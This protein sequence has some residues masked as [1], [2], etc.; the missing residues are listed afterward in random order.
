MFDRIHAAFVSLLVALG[1]AQPATVTYQGYGEGEYVLVAPQIAGTLEALDVER[2]QTVHKG[3]PL[4][5]LDSTD[6]TAALEQAKAQVLAARASLDDMIKAKR[7]SE[8]DTLV[9]Q[10]DQADA[11]L[12][13]AVVTYARDQQQ[14]KIKAVSQQTL[15]ADKAAVDQ[16][17][18]H[19]AETEA[20]VATGQLSTGRDDAIHAA[21]A[22]VAVD[23]AAVAEAQWRLDQ[24][25]LVAPTDAFVFDTLYRPGEYIAAGQPVVSL[26]PAP[27]IRA[28]FFVPEPKLA[29]VPAGTEV[30]IHCDSCTE[31]IPAHVTYVSPQAE[32]SPPELYNQD[33]RARLL[34]MLEATPDENPELLHPGQPVDVIV[35]N[36]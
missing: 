35:S 14:F 33:N 3:D 28:R 10:R 13:L 23:A 27:Y 36:K 26:L 24:K 7:P 12:K 9:A 34:F 6:E 1:L 32:Y 29:S 2:G 19:L 4:F 15:D 31:N 16:A 11:A 17:R 21:A 8:I 20:D 25:T 5:A 18:G 22:T 30:E